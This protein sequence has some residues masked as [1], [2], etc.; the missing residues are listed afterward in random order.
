MSTREDTKRNPP[1]LRFFH[2]I[3]YHDDDAS[4]LLVD[5]VPE[6]TQRTSHTTLRGDEQR[7]ALVVL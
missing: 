3:C 5:H 1:N 4:V 6:I 7:T 2:L